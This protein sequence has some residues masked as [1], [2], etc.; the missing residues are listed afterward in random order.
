MFKPIIPCLT[1]LFMWDS[2]A[3]G[4]NEVQ[5]VANN[6]SLN[7]TVF[8]THSGA[9]VIGDGI[10]L[11][12][13]NIS[14]T[15][16][17]S[18][19]KKTHTILAEGDVMIIYD[20]RIFIADKVQYNF[21]EKTGL[22]YNATT[23]DNLWF[24]SGKKVTLEKD[25]TVKINKAILTSSEHSTPEFALHAKSLTL[26]PQNSLSAKG[27]KITY[28]NFPL[29]Y[30]PYFYTSL[31]TNEDSKIN[32]KLT[33]DSGQGPKFSMRYQIFSNEVS[34]LFFRFDFR[35]KRGIAGA[36]EG[37]YLPDSKLVDFRSKNYLAHDTF[38][39]DNNPNQK[40]TRY[41]LQGI[42]NARN[43]TENFKAFL[44]YDKYSDV[45]MPLDFNADDF[46]LNT[47][48]KTELII[49]NSDPLLSTNFYLRPKI[50]SFQGF[51]QEI[52][53]LK[54]GFKP[55]NIG[56]TGAIFE[57]NCNFSY[58][59]YQ[60][61]QSLLIPIPS[62]HSGR[63]E[64]HETIK[65]PFNLFYLNLTPWVGYDG[66]FYS[67]S[68]SSTP[69]FENLLLYGISANT[70][71]KSSSGN[72][73]HLIKPYADFFTLKPLSLKNHYLFSYDDGFDP[74][75]VLKV[76][77][78]NHFYY[79]TLK[80]DLDIYALRFYNQTNL[81]NN[82]P[83]VGFNFDVDQESVYFYSKCIYNTENQVF[84]QA[85]FGMKW[86]INQYVALKTEFRHRGKYG[87]RKVDYDDYTL[88]VTQNTSDLLISPIS[89]P[90]NA[91]N[92][93]LQ[94]NISRSTQL[95]YESN[96]GWARKNQPSY[97]EFRFDLLKM[98]ATNWRLRVSFM[99]LV[100]DDQVTFGLS[101]V[102]NP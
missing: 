90:R 38:F 51:K 52:P 95:R 45:N 56:K 3:A 63:L 74:Y 64:L 102:P 49:Q 87:F 42:L 68:P 40:R 54:L 44:R 69:S 100:N 75:Q 50:N 84:D 9:I 61:N 77:L 76:G 5:I 48:L 14:Y 55:L 85:N 65:R 21:I 25:Y 8:E 26:K 89:S 59:N 31:G 93:S 57:N 1:L 37:S 43:E 16:D 72:F 66:I 41:R 73:S 36:I 67:N 35:I 12:A 34:D 13:K 47:A 70:L 18:S 101:L 19:E 99:H 82:F 98:I 10:R 17:L 4:P 6:L 97:H 96:I 88:D 2:F 33:W 83:K 7:D 91:A 22:L 20:H 62:Y 60:Y 58:L 27:L 39:N 53:T 32:Y 71:L 29:I 28:L 24:I 86:T 15:R 23:Y 78:S 92:A 79:N 81:K 11:Q 80:C 94:I 30:F 46:E